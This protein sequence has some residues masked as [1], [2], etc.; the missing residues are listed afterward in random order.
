[1]GIHHVLVA[2]PSVLCQEGTPV[3]LR[4][5]HQLQTLWRGV[6]RSRVELGRINYSRILLRDMKILGMA[7]VR[8][9]EMS[10]FEIHLKNASNLYRKY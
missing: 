1:M 3:G 9:T 10:N 8:N 4:G 7:D 6:G 2:L 5:A